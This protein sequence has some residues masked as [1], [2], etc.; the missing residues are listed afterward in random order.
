MLAGEMSGHLFFAERYYGYDD[1]LY[2]SLELV[3][4]L[5]DHVA[6]GGRSLSELF[7]D[8]PPTHVTPEIRTDCPE[9]LKFELVDSIR[10]RL[11]EIVSDGTDDVVIKRIS[12]VDGVR[13]Q[14]EAG[15]GLVRASNTQ[16]I[17]VS[18]FEAK[19]PAALERYRSFMQALIDECREEL[20]AGV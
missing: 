13:V 19:D 20:L 3:R 1:A 6:A 8:L 17:L 5:R 4:I 12:E 15:W 9:E 14:F 10:T 7:R 16:P 2:A 11:E 18:R